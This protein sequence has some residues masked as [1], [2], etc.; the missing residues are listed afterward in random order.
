MD[1][2]LL[3]PIGVKT[4]DPS[5]L[6]YF[7]YYDNSEQSS[8]FETAGGFSYH[9]GPEWLWPF[10]AYA[11]ARLAIAKQLGSAEYLEKTRKSLGPRLGRCL[12]TIMETP[13]RGLPELT[14]ADG[15]YCPGSCPSQAWSISCFLEATVALA[16][17]VTIS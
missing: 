7:G 17:A 4:L 10:G 6:R 12:A 9:Q 8:R 14:N 13:W 1:E 2:I 3:G 16:D 5:D 11:C 15:K